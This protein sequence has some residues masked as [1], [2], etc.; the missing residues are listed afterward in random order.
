MQVEP[1]LEQTCTRQGQIHPVTDTH[2]GGT[3]YRA[4]KMPKLIKLH[5]IYQPDINP[6]PT[7]VR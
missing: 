5:V 2:N 7:I 3:N 4:T 1:Q 6:M